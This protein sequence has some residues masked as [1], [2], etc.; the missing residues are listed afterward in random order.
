MFTDFEL[1]SKKAHLNFTRDLCDAFIRINSHKFASHLVTF[2][3]LP[4]LLPL[5]QNRNVRPG[6]AANYG[7]LHVTS[8]IGEGNTEINEW[9]NKQKQK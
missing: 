4:E 3:R 7:H 9:R 2:K 5:S 6:E 8:W 1:E